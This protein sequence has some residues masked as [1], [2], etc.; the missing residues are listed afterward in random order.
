MSSVHVSGQLYT[1]LL[2]VVAKI[3]DHLKSYLNW[4]RYMGLYV[5]LKDTLAIL[6]DI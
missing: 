1:A 5:S 2:L 6:F 4:D 3:E